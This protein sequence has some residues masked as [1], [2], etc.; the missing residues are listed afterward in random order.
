MLGHDGRAIANFVL[1]FCESRSRPLSNLALQKVVYFCHAWSLIELQRPLI[2]HKFEAWEYGP[3]LPYLY[4]EFKGSDRSPILGR[5]TSIDPS[6][7]QRRIV[8]YDFDEET[9]FLLSNITDFYTR[10][11]VSDLVE[12]SHAK[13]GPWYSVWFHG[14][15]V[16]PGMQIDDQEIIRFYS[17]AVRPFPIQ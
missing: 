13:G 8:Q 7:G 4:R 16:N 3:V 5:A 6:S 12:L 2:R 1:D 14:G 9:D 11:R 10:L 15:K 17:K